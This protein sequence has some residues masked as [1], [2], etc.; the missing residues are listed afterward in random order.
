M[1]NSWTQQWSLCATWIFITDQSTSNV[2][3]GRIQIYSS[4]GCKTWRD[5]L[6]NN[7]LC[8]LRTAIHN[9][10]TKVWPSCEVKACLFHLEQSWWRQIQSSG[11]SKQYGEKDSEVSQFLKKIF[12]LSL[13]PPATALHL[14]NE[15]RVAQ[16]CDYLLEHYIDTDSTFPP[17]VLS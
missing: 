14:P 11:L 7:C 5:C 9:A 13:L 17:P 16:F 12:G 6:S 15:R 3:W 8:W 1:H 4:R 10:V 2:I